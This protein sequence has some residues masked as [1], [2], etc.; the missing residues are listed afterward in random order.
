MVGVEFFGNFDLA[1][2][3]I[4]SFYI[5]FAGL[6]YYLQTEN[7]REGFPL[8]DEDGNVAPNQGP[9]PLP[10]DK[11]FILRNG[12]GEVTVP[13]GARGDR[14]DLALERTDPSNGYPYAPTGDPM[15]DGVGP[16]AWAPRRNVPERDGHGHIKI[17]PMD[18]AKEFRVSA[19]RNPIGLPVLSKDDIVIGYITD[20]WVDKPEALVRYLEV[21]LEEEFGKGKRLIPMAMARI[22]RKWVKVSSLHSSRF[23][24]VPRTRKAAEITMLE[25]EKISAWYAGGIMYS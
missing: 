14:D 25:E 21:T 3:A 22:K 4:W 7:M 11:T 5:F 20:L 18:S 19:G 2:A 16:A 17:V 8:E 24:G 6:I 13:S 10:K 15:R 12:E 9:F 23:A 1:S